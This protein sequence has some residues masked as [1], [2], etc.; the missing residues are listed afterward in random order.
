MVL[1]KVAFLVTLSLFIAWM[2]IPS[3]LSAQALTPAQREAQ[4]TLYEVMSIHGE[5]TQEMHSRFWALVDSSSPD[6]RAT[7]AE[8]KF[9]RFGVEPALEIQRETW[10][11]MQQSW[12][13]RRVVK[14]NSLQSL[15]NDFPNA[16][17]SRSPYAVGSREHQEMM[18]TFTR[19]HERS[20]QSV[21]A[22]LEAAGNRRSQVTTPNGT[23]LISIELIETVNEQLDQ[24]F[25]R[26]GSLLQRSWT[27]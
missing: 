7:E 11:S 21:D 6:G 17:R 5:L 14:T 18:R 23:F 1:R 10:R 22:W 4:Q 3:V 8:I 9:M 25:T 19:E 12:Y 24:S 26:L 13:Q 27:E 2:S 16:I 15:M 20:F